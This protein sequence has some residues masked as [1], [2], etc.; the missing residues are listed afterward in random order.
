MASKEKILLGI[1]PGIGRMGYGVLSVIG[2]IVKVKV[3]GCI[4]TDKN[5]DLPN[6]LLC[7]FM[8][9]EKIFEEHQPQLVCVEE[10]FFSKNVTSGL[11][12]AHARGLVLFLAAR[13]GIPVREY[14]PN[15]IKQ[16]LTGYGRAEKKQMREMIRLVLRMDHAPRSDD[17]ADALA[18][19]WCG[20]GSS[21]FEGRLK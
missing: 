19:A 12:V 2:S 3:Y 14:K 4:E 7:V 16:A 21:S 9:L 15:Q 17:A 10:L 1:D 8:E 6:R 5:F 11:Q 20:V 13:S 18:V